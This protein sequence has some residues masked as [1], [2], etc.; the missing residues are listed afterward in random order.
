[1]KINRLPISEIFVESILLVKD[2][3]LELLRLGMPLIVVSFF[4][5]IYS[6]YYSESGESVSTISLSG[7]LIGLVHALTLLLATIGAHR[8]FIMPDDQVTKTKPLRWTWRETR[9]LG[10]WI[11]LALVVV[12]IALPLPI[13]FIGLN[14]VVPS[15]ISVTEGGGYGEI[16]LSSLFIIMY[17]LLARLSLVLPATA[18]DQKGKSLK[19]SWRLSQGNSIRLLIIIGGIPLLINI[20]LYFLPESEGIVLSLIYCTVGLIVGAV[21]ICLLSLSFNFLSK[22]NVESKNTNSETLSTQDNAG[23]DILN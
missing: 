9:F 1:M 13:L 21:E 6:T 20:F 3:Y 16:I 12:L 7:T 14:S 11:V 15:A 22:T 23:T 10:W 8:V 17:Y 2:K 5:T 18:I 19:W 4:S